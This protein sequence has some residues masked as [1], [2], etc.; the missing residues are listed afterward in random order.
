[1]KESKK[2]YLKKIVVLG[3]DGYQERLIRLPT[4]THIQHFKNLR[5]QIIKKILC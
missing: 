2:H 1:M 3:L 4:N 5:Q